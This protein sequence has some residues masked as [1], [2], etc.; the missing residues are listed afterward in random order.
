LNVQNQFNAS[1]S[2][3]NNLWQKY[4]DN[5]S[6]NFQKSESQLQRQHEVGIMAMEFANS[7]SIY[8]KEQKDNLA[9]GVG[10]WIAAWMGSS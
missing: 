2:A 8:D 10:N 9:S 3:L 6:W 4:R 1:Q 5:A 7:N